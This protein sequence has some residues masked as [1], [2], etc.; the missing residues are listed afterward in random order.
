ME[1]TSE[2][3]DEDSKVNESREALLE[4]SY[5]RPDQR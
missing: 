1:L 5:C 2:G 4:L 3:L